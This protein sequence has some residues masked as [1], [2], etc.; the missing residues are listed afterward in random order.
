MMELAPPSFQKALRFATRHAWSLSLSGLSTVSFVQL[1]LEIEEG[2][3]SDFD[4]AVARLLVV[5]RGHWDLPM[6]ALT[7]LGN[8]TSL[9]FLCVSTTAF[10]AWLGKRREAAYVLICS[11]GAALFC[12]AL[13]LFFQ[14]ARP[15]A[16]TQY[17]LSVPSSFS[18]PSGHAMGSISVLASLAIAYRVLNPFK[19]WRLLG[20]IIAVPLVLGVGA[21]RVYFGVH[22]PSDVIGGQLAGAA[23]VAAVTGWFYP[24]LL[25]AEASGP[26]T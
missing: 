1:A 23:W 6:L 4:R 17:L 9:A 15:E 7:R 3:L 2:E 24:R 16:V 25:P 11:S 21:S 13:K 18:F 5:H 19:G 12:S 20:V 8:F 10:L 22:Y 26:A 14:R